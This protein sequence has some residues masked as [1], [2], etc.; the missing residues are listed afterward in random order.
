MLVLAACG[1]DGSEA[2]AGSA[3][4]DQGEEMMFGAPADAADADRVVQVTMNDDFSFEPAA[5]DVVAGETITFELVND[6]A[7]EHDFTIGDEATQDAHDSEMAEMADMPGME[8][9]DEEHGADSNAVS[10]GAGQT[11]EITWTFA[12]PGEKILFG[13]HIPGHYAAGMVGEFSLG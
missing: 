4:G 2:S 5:I 6:G 9:D 11:G 1:D 13:C 12:D 8:S 7:I 3:S 10:V